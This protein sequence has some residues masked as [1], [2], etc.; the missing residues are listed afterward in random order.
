M[1]YC[2]GGGLDKE[3]RGHCAADLA[4]V[5]PAQANISGGGARYVAPV[6]VLLVL[7]F[8]RGQG[9]SAERQPLPSQRVSPA[10]AS[11]VAGR[12]RLNPSLT[13]MGTLLLKIT[14]I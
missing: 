10:A 1:A 2:C 13:L 8:V 11:T 5:H 6:R 12:A 14:C 9:S 7:L 3:G 4:R